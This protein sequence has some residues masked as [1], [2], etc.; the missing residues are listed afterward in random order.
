MKIVITGADSFIGRRF[1]KIVTVHSGE[2][3]RTVLFAR[4]W[5]Q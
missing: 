4:Q 2:T 5:E 3:V 1:W